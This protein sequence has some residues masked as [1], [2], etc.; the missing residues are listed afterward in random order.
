MLE[1]LKFTLKHTL[2]YS[3]GNIGTKAIG[4]LLLPLYTTYLTTEEYG[5]FAVLEITSQILVTFMGFR[6][7]TAMLRFTTSEK[8]EDRRKSIVFISV[9]V[10][11]FSVIF[12]NLVLQPFSQDFSN[13]F[14][15]HSRFR[16]YFVLLFIWS[17]FEMFNR[18]F[19][20]FLRIRNQSVFF[21][22]TVLVKVLVIMLLNIYFIVSLN[23]GVKGIILA[24]LIGSLLVFLVILPKVLKSVRFSFDPA[25]FKEMFSYGFPLIFASLSTMLLSMGDRYL[26]KL[27]LSYSEVGVYSLGY[28][29]AGVINI[30][31]IQSFQLGFLPI[32]FKMFDKS[33]AKRY[34]SKV[35]KYYAFILVIFSL[36][37]S[38]FSKELIM[39]LSQKES[40]LVAYTIVPIIALAFSIKGVYYVFSIGLHY[41]KKTSLNAVVYAIGLLISIGLNV[42]LIPHFSYYGAAFVAVCAN[43]FIAIMF[44]FTSQKHYN[45]PYEMK[46]ITGLFVLG[47]L[48]YLISMLFADFSNFYI[49][50]VA[51]LLLFLTFPFVLLIFG[52]YEKV[53]ILAVKGFYKKW[54][55]PANWKKNLKK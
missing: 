34:F 27:F 15:N 38:L 17:S 24:Q 11:F 29:I 46:K 43:I 4:L 36:G 42:L 49:S 1:K 13:L 48:Y 9:I 22:I 50:A 16:D 52:F 37:L 8:S 25:L 53:E 14:F 26:L 20:D 45:V 30:F 7:S 33:G 39:I 18:V 31:L 54:K 55:K 6:F 2:I 44:Y 19:F 12:M 3:L 10:T 51:K 40:F 47:I 32:A 41:V 5:I 35:L 23:Y 28:K 21:M